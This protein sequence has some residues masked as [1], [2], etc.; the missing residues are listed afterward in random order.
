M[1]STW[2]ALFFFFGILHIA[3]CSPSHPQITPPA[4]LKRAIID[5]SF[6]GWSSTLGTCT[7]CFLHARAFANTAR[8]PSDTPI[9]CEPGYTYK[10]FGS[11]ADCCPEVGS[12]R[13]ITACSDRIIQLQG[14]SSLTWYGYLE[15][16]VIHGSPG[17]ILF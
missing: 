8:L 7:S 13:P 1:H 10:N 12:C 15:R 17:L 14:G 16:R 2:L 5:D 11:I 3:S 4:L 6:E 9:Y